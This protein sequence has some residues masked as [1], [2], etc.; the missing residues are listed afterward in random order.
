MIDRYT[1]RQ[2]HAEIKTDRQT[3]IVRKIGIQMTDT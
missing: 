2:R 3:D 1:D